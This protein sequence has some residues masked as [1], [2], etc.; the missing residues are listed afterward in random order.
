[1]CQTSSK[2][3]RTR[4]RFLV[5]ARVRVLVRVRV[6][7][8]VLH[9]CHEHAA[10]G[11]DFGPYAR[12]NLRVDTPLTPEMLMLKINTLFDFREKTSGWRIELDEIHTVAQSDGS[13]ENVE[14]GACVGETVVPI[15]DDGMM[16][17]DFV[18]RGL[19]PET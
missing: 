9:T 16:N 15:F 2:L 3:E 13:S 19:L 10:A 1:M 12:L 5:R 18:P 11:R 17:H 7:V 8:R 14:E 4:L 6:R